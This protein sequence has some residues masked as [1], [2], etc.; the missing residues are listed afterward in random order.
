M[1]HFWNKFVIRAQITSGFV[2]LILL[3]SLLTVS[4][5][6]GMNGLASIF[7]SYRAT[8][9][10]ILAISDYSRATSFWRQALRTTSL[11]AMLVQGPN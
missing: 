3:M 7:A 10:Q 4:A 5:I 11:S 1:L 2:P 9:G 6:S 8:A